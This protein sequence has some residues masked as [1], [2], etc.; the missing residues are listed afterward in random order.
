VKGIVEADGWV[1]E[2]FPDT[3]FS[4]TPFLFVDGRPGKRKVAFLR[5]RVSGVG[6]RQV[7]AAH[8][9]LRGLGGGN[10]NGTSQN[11]QSPRSR[12]SG[13]LTSQIRRCNWTGA[14]I[15]WNTQPTIDASVLDS[16]NAGGTVD[17]DVSGAIRGDGIYCFALDQT[18]NVQTLYGARESIVWAPTLV[19][20]LSQ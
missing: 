3:S 1:H 11:G 20:E 13:G 14:T 7:L 10:A 19:V 5:V 4:R 2:Q 15:T 6:N 8:L 9:H 16:A 17:F 12:N 18:A